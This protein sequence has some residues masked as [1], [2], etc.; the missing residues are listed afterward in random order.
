[1]HGS[2]MYNVELSIVL[3]CDREDMEINGGT[4]E[5]KMK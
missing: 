5:N 3:H 1:M 4:T 2:S